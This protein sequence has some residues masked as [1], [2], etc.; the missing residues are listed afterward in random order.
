VNFVKRRMLNSKL[1]E[2]LCSEMGSDHDKLLV[3]TEVWWLSRR[4]VLKL[5]V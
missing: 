4:K 1:F 5:C 3:Q 2:I